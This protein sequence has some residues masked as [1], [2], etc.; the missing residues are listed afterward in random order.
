M[1][2]DTVQGI[3]DNLEENI[4]TEAPDMKSPESLAAARNYADS[5]IGLGSD[6]I[7]RLEQE[8]VQRVDLRNN[9]VE[10]LG[11]KLAK[12]KLALIESE[13]ERGPIS[14]DL[15]MPAYGEINR[16]KK[17]G[18]AD[19]ES[20]NINGEDLI[21]QKAAQLAWLF[22]GT[23]SRY[24]VTIVDD[25]CKYG[26]G[27]Y[28]ERIIDENGLGGNFRVLY[29]EDAIKQEKEGEDQLLNAALQHSTFPKSPDEKKGGA[30]LYG[31]AKALQ[32]HEGDSN[33][34]VGY[35]DCDLS[36]DVAQ[37][38]NLIKEV[39]LG[40]SAVA[41]GSRRL[42]ES[43]YV[44]GG[45]G[46]NSR[47]NL[48]RYLRLLTIQGLLPVDTQCGA[49]AFRADALRQIIMSGPKLVDMSFDIEMLMQSGL[50]FGADK[51]KPVAVAWFD[52]PEESTAGSTVHYE[53]ARDQAEISTSETGKINPA[54]YQE[55]LEIT[56]I[57]TASSD[58][59]NELV[60]IFNALPETHPMKAYFA[61]AIKKLKAGELPDDQF[62]AEYRKLAEQAKQEVLGTANRR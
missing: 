8:A 55:A 16:M 52:S 35:T 53:M 5:I 4:V 57:A 9:H 60:N 54:A 32:E 31:L 18:A 12:S 56:Q 61:G 47:A 22:A 17:R 46:R 13:R 30:V 50:L 41:A 10:Q 45:E 15:V 19:D 21:N 2:H 44:A 38:G 11:I 43:V 6:E 33:H 36:V 48:A 59:W 40:D 49:K 1:G 39:T 7:S 25:I 51:T 62:L 26:S 27:K 3:I 20:Q 14:F 34:V 42:P 37:F 58:V 24:R 23:N 28:A 29:L